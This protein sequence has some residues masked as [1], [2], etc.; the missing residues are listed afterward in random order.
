[1]AAQSKE[2][3]A[4]SESIQSQ[5]SSLAFGGGSK[6][7]GPFSGVRKLFR[8]ATQT[9]Y[10]GHTGPRQA[11]ASAGRPALLH[12]AES[13]SW[14]QGGTS[15]LGACA[16]GANAHS[17][18]SQSTRSERPPHSHRGRQVVEYTAARCA[19][20]TTIVSRQSQ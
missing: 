19:P 14:R 1:M 15:E 12:Q 7:N 8:C 11:S 6:K 13:S 3:G 9:G 18:R 5:I 4:G 17:A 16:A 10:A 20:F 2:E